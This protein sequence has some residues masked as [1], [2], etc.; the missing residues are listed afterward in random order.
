MNR[1]IKG[2]KD[3]T[4][5]TTKQTPGIREIVLDLSTNGSTTPL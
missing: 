1:L 2:R 5:D 4:K 3:M